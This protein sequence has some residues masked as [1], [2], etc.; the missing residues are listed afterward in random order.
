MVPPAGVATVMSWLREPSAP[1]IRRVM[2]PVTLLSD[3]AVRPVL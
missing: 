3:E 1:L 2:L